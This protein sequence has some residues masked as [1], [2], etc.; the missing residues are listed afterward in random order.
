MSELSEPK[1]YRAVRTDDFLEA[2]FSNLLTATEEAQTRTSDDLAILIRNAIMS[3]LNDKC[4]IS[5]LNTTG[6]LL[7]A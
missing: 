4:N 3:P 2:N 7:I 5:L 1:C 6:G